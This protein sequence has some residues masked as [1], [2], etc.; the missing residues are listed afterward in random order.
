MGW[1]DRLK[2]V[3][4]TKIDYKYTGTDEVVYED[5]KLITNIQEYDCIADSLLADPTLT[6]TTG[7]TIVPPLTSWDVSLG[8]ISYIGTSGGVISQN[9]LVIDE[10]YDVEMD[11]LITITNPSDSI[12]VVVGGETFVY[13]ESGN[14]TINQSVT[15]STN[16]FS[17]TAQHLGELP[18]A[19]R[20]ENLCL[21]P[22]RSFDVVDLDNSEYFENCSWTI[23]YS[24]LSKTWISYYS[25]IPNYYVGYNDYFQTGINK[26][27]DEFGLWSHFS[28][29]SSY[30]VFYGKLYPFTIE[31]VNQTRAS[32]STI[33]TVEF[34]LDV[35][36]YYNKYDFSDIV[37]YGFNK[38]VVYN[39]FQNTGQLELVTQKGNSQKQLLD[40]PKYNSLSTSILQ[41][42]IAGKWSFNWLYNQIRDEK[43]GLPLWIN[44][45][46]QINKELNSKLFNYKNKFKDRLRGDYFL[47]R[48]T[49]DM[50]SRYKML[51]RY[52]FDNRDYFEQ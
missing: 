46:A 31:Y 14:Y 36:K 32:N 30:Q 49:Q 44:D 3:F 19:C 22:C 6:S 2:R 27:G 16:E 20:I 17:I 50:E 38:A 37:G 34:Y 24:P 48:L 33:Q 5:G 40:Y 28:F 25:F 52:A 43:S 51:F 41:S 39:N 29:L 18:L 1:D 23:G 42:E 12:T 47:I 26:E 45:C 21:K 9:V 13:T 10:C 7:W 11:L 8:I 15:A 35:R 4:L